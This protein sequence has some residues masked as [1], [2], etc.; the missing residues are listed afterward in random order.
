MII[1]SPKIMSNILVFIYLISNIIGAKCS[2]VVQ[3]LICCQSRIVPSVVSP[4]EEQ[5]VALW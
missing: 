2:P 4:L 3:H 1:S 5:D